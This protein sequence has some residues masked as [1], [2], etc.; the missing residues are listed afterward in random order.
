MKDFNIQLA[1]V[2]LLVAGAVFYL[3]RRTV[4]GINAKNCEGDCHSVTST[5][6]KKENQKL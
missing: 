2:I 6:S 5:K 3:I 4:R 1:L